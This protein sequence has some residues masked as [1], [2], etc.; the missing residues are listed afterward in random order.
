MR[1]R[2]RGLGH[3]FLETEAAMAD[4]MRSMAFS[5]SSDMALYTQLAAAWTAHVIWARSQTARESLTRLL[6]TSQR[7]WDLPDPSRPIQTRR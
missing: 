7:G 6:V 1:G 3:G 5:D 4:S 2:V